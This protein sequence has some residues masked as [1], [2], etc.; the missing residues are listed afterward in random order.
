MIKTIVLKMFALIQKKDY[1]KAKV[2]KEKNV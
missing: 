1:M 2:K